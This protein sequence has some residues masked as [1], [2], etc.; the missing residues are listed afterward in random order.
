MSNLISL[1]QLPLAP[2]EIVWLEKQLP[3]AP[4][5]FIL[6]FV[7]GGGHR[8][9]K[10]FRMLSHEEFSA[11]SQDQLVTNIRAEFPGAIAFRVLTAWSMIFKP[12]VSKPEVL[13]P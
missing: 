4:T 7:T 6:V 1:P 2:D 13:T 11:L 5:V 10:M 3:A 8:S 12:A 9:W